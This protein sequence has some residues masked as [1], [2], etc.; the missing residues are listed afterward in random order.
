PPGEY[1]LRLDKDSFRPYGRGGIS[2]R[3]AGTFQVNAEILP[4]NVTLKAEEIVVVGKA[5]TV[6]VGSSSTGVSVNQDFTSHLPLTGGPASRSFESLATVAPGAQSDRYGVS[7]NGTPSPENAFVID[8]VSVN[9]PAFGI[10]GT[11]LSVE[12][13]KELNVV[14][15]GYMPE[16]GRSMG[17]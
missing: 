8:G 6:D 1:S 4:E 15:G 13:V 17:G 3:S 2:M 7:I 5:P 16:F 12:F 11:P 14:S 9:N 10:L